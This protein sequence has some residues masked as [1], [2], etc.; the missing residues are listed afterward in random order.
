MAG[1]LQETK[2]LSVGQ[3][4]LERPCSTDIDGHSESQLL[5]KQDLRVL[6]MVFLMYFFTFLDRTNLGNAR[7]AGMEKDLGLGTYGFNIGACLYYLIYFFADIPAALCVKKFGFIVIPLSCIAFGA[8]TIGTAF[9][10]N[11]A[12][13]Y[14]IRLLLGLTESFQFPGLNYVISR[15]YRRHEVTLR[16]SFFMLGSAGLAG[17][18]GGLLASG[19]LA[20]KTVGSVKSWRVI[21]LVEGIITVGVGFI[22]L[23]LFPA[24][25]SRTRIFNDKERA[26]A[27]KRIFKD[28]PAIQEHKEK[29]TWALVKRGIF[30]VNVMV[31]AWIY[32]C[33][34][35]T[36]Q[37]LS[38]FTATILRLNF[39]ERSLIQIQ[40]LSAAPPMVGMVFS[41]GVAYITMKTR[42]HGIA[43][44]GCAC[45]CVLGYSIWLGSSNPQARFA[46]IFF[47]T[48]GGYGFG[49][50]IVGWTLSN[51]APDTVKNVANAAVSGLANIGSIVATWSYINTDAKNGYRIGNSLNTATAIT[52]IVAALGLLAYQVR[53]NKK[54]A[55]GGRDYRLQRSEA[56]VAS[57]GHLH[58]KF[59]YIH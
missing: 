42:K 29:I 2:E 15:Y 44:A 3:I 57:L 13:F 8:V 56:E 28:Q 47:N 49:V 53:E 34:Q 4:D 16:I 38:I 10:H 5:R 45:L 50:L 22:S 9:I 25:P 11:S 43:T 23:W 58:P 59:R 1:S 46:A 54:R 14:A 17:G 20:L 51:A 55:A 41:L 7:I 37:G 36:V 48:A 35:I 40:L 26:L 33:D 18:F 21:F 19:L 12:S 39:P 24:D 32:T 52:V 6:P 27:M 31:G 30:N